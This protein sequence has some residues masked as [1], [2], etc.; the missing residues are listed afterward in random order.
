[1]H[2]PI[3]GQVRLLSNVKDHAAARNEIALSFDPSCFSH[4][5]M[6]DE[7]TVPPMGFIERML[8]VNRPVVSG[9]THVWRAKNGCLEPRPSLALWRQKKLVSE[10]YYEFVPGIPE[11]VWEVPGIATGCFCMLIKS[12]VLV[13]YREKLGLPFFKTTYYEPTQE[14]EMSEDIY[15]CKRLAEIGV[16]ITII[17]DLVCRHFKQ[18]ALADVVEYGKFMCEQGNAN[19]KK[20]GVCDVAET[21]FAK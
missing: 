2:N 11:A 6:I 7:D 13:V 10:S 12:E 8:E 19:N 1:M 4:L 14:K 5:L 15:F 21:A 18:V 20:S 3:V 16:N 9:V 17:R